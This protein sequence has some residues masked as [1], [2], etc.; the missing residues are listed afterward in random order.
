FVLR[1]LLGRE[2]HQAGIC[3]SDFRNAF[4]EAAGVAGLPR[5]PGSK[6]GEL[7]SAS[8]WTLLLTVIAEIRAHFAGIVGEEN[9]RCQAGSVR[10]VTYARP[11]GGL[12][13]HLFKFGCT[14]CTEKSN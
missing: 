7:S 2:F 14:A 3:V 12:D 13:P 4:R 9:S 5:L 1:A 6:A 8:L 10:V 11:T